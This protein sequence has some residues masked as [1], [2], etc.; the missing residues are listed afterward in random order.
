[1]P[2]SHVVGLLDSQLGVH[3]YLLHFINVST[4]LFFLGFVVF[5]DNGF[6]VPLVGVVILF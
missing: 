6:V 1:M 2:F 4:Q 5:L 3:G